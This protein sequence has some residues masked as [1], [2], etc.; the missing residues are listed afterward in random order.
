MI[1]ATWQEMDANLGLCRY[2]YVEFTE[3]AL[4]AQ[5]LVLNE[6]VLRGR[7]LKVGLFVPPCVTCLY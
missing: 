5:A 3:P 2:A 6:S 1:N 7:N 4:V